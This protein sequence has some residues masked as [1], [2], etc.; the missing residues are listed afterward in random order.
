VAAAAA[1]KVDGGFMERQQRI[2]PWVCEEHLQLQDM[3]RGFFDAE[4]APNIARWCKQGA[5]DRDFWCKAGELGLLGASVPEQFGGSGGDHGHDMVIFREQGRSG[6]ANWGLS[7]HSIVT[8]Y[9]VN[10]AS[11]DQKQRWLPKMVTGEFVGA[12]AM[13]EP[14]AGSDLKAIRT[15]A[16]KEGDNYVVNGSK[17][18]I[19]NGQTADLIVIVAKTEPS[20]GHKGVSLV[21]LDE[22]ETPGFRRGRNLEKVG[23]KGQDT[24]ELFFDDVRIPQAN[25]LGAEE[26]QGFYQLMK[27][28]AYERTIIGVK[29]LGNCELAIS[30]TLRYVKDRKAFDKRL[31]DFQNTRFKLAEC[32]AQLE[33]LRAFVDRCITDM[34]AGKLDGP[35]AAILKYWSS[36]A[37]GKIMDECLQLFG[38]YGYMMEYPIA[39]LY[40]DAR[41][42]RILGGT[43]EIQKEIIARSLDS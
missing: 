9:L 16:I 34:L 5:V 3:A 8:H 31:M 27:E 19:T 29:A 2:A 24:S 7:V 43:S 36:E 26:G 10:F 28:L 6:D 13:T 41:V 4:L 37:Q 38:G 42:S 39:R 22:T 11:Q 25:L 35:T 21:I 23:L 17:T 1:F 40:I 30:E 32:Q 33:V 12:I 15:T 18:F 14:G 20:A